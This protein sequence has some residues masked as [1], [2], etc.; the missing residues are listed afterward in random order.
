MYIKNY[1][2]TSE[3]IRLDHEDPLTK[4]RITA[5]NYNNMIVIEAYSP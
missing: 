5:H 3:E 1:K 4:S 2:G